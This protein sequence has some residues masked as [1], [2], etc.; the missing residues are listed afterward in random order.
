MKNIYRERLLQVRSLRDRGLQFHQY[1]TADVRQSPTSTYKIYNAYLIPPANI[2]DRLKRPQMKQGTLSVVSPVIQK[3]EV[4]PALSDKEVTAARETVTPFPKG[5]IF[6]HL[7]R[8]SS[9]RHGRHQK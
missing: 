4:C 9:S 3:V 5:V 1:K 2:L 6:I 7:L 8:I